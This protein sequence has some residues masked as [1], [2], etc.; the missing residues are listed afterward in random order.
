MP[1]QAERIGGDEETHALRR[2]HVDGVLCA[3]GISHPGSP[4]RSTDRA[5]AWGGSSWCVVQDHAQALV[6][7]E[8]MGVDLPNST[9]SIDQI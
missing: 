4:V 9:P 8:W 2:L 7:A 5:G 6:V 3:P 1:S